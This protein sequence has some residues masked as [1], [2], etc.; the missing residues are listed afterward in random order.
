MDICKNPYIVRARK[1]EDMEQKDGHHTWTPG[2]LSMLQ[3]LLKGYIHKL[4]PQRFAWH[5]Q[6]G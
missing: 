1:L 4:E 3:S 2:S 6:D 5:P